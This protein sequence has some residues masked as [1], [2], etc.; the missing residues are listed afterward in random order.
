MFLG[1]PAR[2][3]I[4]PNR[5]SCA[6]SHDDAQ[7][8][9]TCFTEMVEFLPAAPVPDGQHD[10]QHMEITRLPGACVRFRPPALGVVI[11]GAALEFRAPAASWP[12]GVRI[13]RKAQPRAVPVPRLKAPVFRGSG[14]GYPQAR[15]GCDRLLQWPIR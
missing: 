13:C 14:A 2:D 6:I 3:L 12:R 7:P 4:D 9:S 8:V 1:H 5:F 15:Y 11:A 10:G